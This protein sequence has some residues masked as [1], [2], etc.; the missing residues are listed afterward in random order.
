MKKNKG[1]GFSTV[2]L[3]GLLI[4][5]VVFI[6]LNLMP[7]G[8]SS[9][10]EGPP[11]YTIETTEHVISPSVLLPTDSPSDKPGGFLVT[12]APIEDDQEAVREELERINEALKKAAR[13]HA[14]CLRRAAN[15]PTGVFASA[16]DKAVEPLIRNLQAHQ[17]AFFHAAVNETL[18]CIGEVCD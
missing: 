2:I 7:S 9:P 6:Y 14:E 13:T 4:G 15:D 8:Q 5:A 10:L 3:I 1:N 16:C 12:M 17:L 11:S 18:G